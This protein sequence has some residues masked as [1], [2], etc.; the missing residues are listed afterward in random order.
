MSVRKR[1]PGFGAKH[2]KRVVKKSTKKPKLS[3]TLKSQAKRHGVRVTL[4]R[5]GKRVEKTEKLLKKQ[6][7]MAMKR[8]LAKKKLAS[9][10]KKTVRKVKRKVKRKTVRK[11][12]RKTKRKSSK[13]GKLEVPAG[14]KSV[15]QMRDQ[16][17]F[18]GREHRP[19]L[20]APHGPP[21]R[22]LLKDETPA[23]SGAPAFGKNLRK[24]NYG[25]GNSLAGKRVNPSGYLST[26]YGAPRV[27]PPA[28]NSLLLQG[29]NNFREGIND[30]TL[31]NVGTGYGRKRRKTTRKPK[32]RKTTRKPKRRKSKRK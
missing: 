10:K 16:A 11:S 14:M 5:N 9:K 25:F 1:R 12:K 15:S 6:I 22:W 3:K 20:I 31:S 28:W 8:K 24:R 18:L 7:K 2:K 4:K 19:L 23:Y 32:R 27:V 30:P 13:F 21:K 26:W 17:R 29:Q